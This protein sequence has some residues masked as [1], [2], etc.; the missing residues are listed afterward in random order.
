MPRDGTVNKIC[1]Q[2]GCSFNWLKYGEG[3][4]FQSTE[5]EGISSEIDPETFGDIQKW[6][7]DQEKEKPGFNNWF[8][9][10]FRNR[11]P[12]FDKWEKKKEE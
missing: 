3:E 7:N 8:K 10:E 4:M 1:E 9:I 2:F 12:E 11:F 6:L 5:G